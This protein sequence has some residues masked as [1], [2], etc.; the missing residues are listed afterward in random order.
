MRSFAGR[1]IVSLKDF[2]RHEF[3]R[4]FQIADKLLPI[5]QN[6][7]NVDLLKDKTLVTAF[8]QPSTRTRLAHE[9]AMLRLGGKVV[10]VADAMRTSSAWKGESLRDTIRTIDNYAD[11]I[12]LRHPEAGAAEK[13]A[14]Y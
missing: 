7:K 5:A 14:Q 10:S 12:V 2:E 8:Y 3:E 9:A 6:R 11:V 4:I 1:D 13:A